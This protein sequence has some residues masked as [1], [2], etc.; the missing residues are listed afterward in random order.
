MS[1]HGD[2]KSQL[3]VDKKDF[4]L[5]TLYQAFFSRALPSD[6]DVRLEYDAAVE[7]AKPEST[8]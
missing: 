7:A 4:E 1:R 3:V 5:E 8:L 2:I 6:H